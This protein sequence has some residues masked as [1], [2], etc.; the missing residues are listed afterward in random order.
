MLKDVLTRTVVRTLIMVSM[1]H[2]FD[3]AYLLKQEHVTEKTATQALLTIA[4][5]K[6]YQQPGGEKMPSDKINDNIVVQTMDHSVY[7]HPAFP[8]SSEL[9]SYLA[10]LYFISLLRC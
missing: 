8:C 7:H 2:L 10:N 5:I 6:L 4:V 1:C 3:G 9:F